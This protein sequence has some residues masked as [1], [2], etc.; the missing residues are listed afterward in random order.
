MRKLCSKEERV[1]KDSSPCSQNHEISQE[2]LMKSLKAQ[3][4]YEIS[5]GNL[6]TAQKHEIS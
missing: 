6:V 2:N 1:H 3:K 5:D 4:L